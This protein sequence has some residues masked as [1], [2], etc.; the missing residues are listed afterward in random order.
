MNHKPAEQ[1]AGDLVVEWYG[2]HLLVRRHDEG[3]TFIGSFGWPEPVPAQVFVLVSPEAARDPSAVTVLP[4]LLYRKLVAGDNASVR[5]GLPGLG[6]DPLVPQALADVLSKDVLAPDG[7]FATTPGAALFAGYGTGGTGWTRFRP[8]RTSSPG[9]QRHPVPEWEDALPETPVTAAGVTAEPIPAGIVVRRAQGRPATPTD[10]AFGIP[11]DLAAARIVIGG[12]KDV[13]EPAAAAALVAKLPQVTTQ[14]VVLAPAAGTH[15][16][17]SAYARS[18]GRDVVVVGSVGFVQPF[19]TK[20]KQRVDGF[21]EI[22]QA[23]EP[24]PGWQ[25]RDHSGYRLGAVM[26]D[27]VPSGVVL[28]MGIA[29]PATRRQPFAPD[30]WTLY[31]GTPGSPIEPDVL[32][33]AESLLGSVSPETRRCARLQLLGVLD[34]RARE[35]FDRTPDDA[36][37]EIKVQPTAGAEP[38]RPAPPASPVPVMPRALM[39]SAAPVATVSGS[40]GAVPASP[41]ETT[42]SLPA[43]VEQPP[44][45]VGHQASEPSRWQAMPPRPAVL[46]E[47][48]VER[49]RVSETGS[50]V[51]TDRGNADDDVLASPFDGNAPVAVSEPMVATVESGASVRSGKPLA[52]ADR[53]S[54]GAEQMRFTAAAGD[55]YSEALATVNAA[56]ATWPSMRQEDT[57]GVKADYVAVCLYLGR[58]LGNSSELNAAVRGGNDGAVDGYVHCLASGL[59]RLPT[60]RRAVLRQGAAAQSPERT[61]DPGKVLTEPGFLS[62][63]TDL[64]VAVPGADLDVLIWP[65]SARRTSELKI[66]QSVNE[67]VFFAGARFKALA[68]RTA[69]QAVEAEDG[70]LAVPRTAALFRELAPNESVPS[71]GELDEL[72]LAVLAKLDRALERRRRG[73]LRLVDEPETRDRLTTSLLEWHEDM[74]VT[75]S[76]AR[77]ATLAS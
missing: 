56:L 73:S 1:A 51:E 66:G 46:A 17:L 25:R 20:L 30:T 31:L 3:N 52:I 24:P 36:N 70:N 2:R 39:V 15:S 9:G 72:D 60:H 28:R 42:A 62:G 59:R 11:V 37:A 64:D 8:G 77:T 6:K 69:E 76:A 41:P 74:V 19:V 12:D 7:A 45:G 53:A 40:P 10:P 68:I 58:G 33:A 4:S 22:L 26:A 63:C 65:A 16:W 5:I 67:V 57:A 23:A 44:T 71:T 18:L 75:A 14:L 29:D 54:T 55:I 13:P 27:V 61:V 38:S 35:I 47:A 34:D 49:D 43:E 21:Q 50:R 32:Y 48:A